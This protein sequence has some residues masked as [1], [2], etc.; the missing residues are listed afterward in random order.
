MINYQNMNQQNAVRERELLQEIK[1]SCW[2]S[3]GTG[4]AAPPA[5]STWEMIP[6]T[7]AD[8][9]LL[10]RKSP[11]QRIQSAGGHWKSRRKVWGVQ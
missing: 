2:F 10:E 5:A 11:F 8:S 1:S 9:S 6:Q 4:L 3:G 7:C